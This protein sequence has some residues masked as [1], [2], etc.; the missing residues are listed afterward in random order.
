[1]NCATRGLEPYVPSEDTPWDIGRAQHLFRRIGFGGRP[2]ELEAALEAGPTATVDFLLNQATTRPFY[3]AP[4]FAYWNQETLRANGLDVFQSFMKIQR[5]WVRDAIQY[6]IREKLS[7]FWQNHLVTVYETHSCP[8]YHYQY[9]RVIEEHCFGNYSDFV[10]DMTVTPAMLFYLNGFENTK[11]NP[12]E[13][14]ARELFELFT[15]GEN[16]GYTQEDIVEASRALTGYNGWTS[17]CGGVRYA[18]WGFDDSEKTVFGV[19]GNFNYIELI[20]LLFEQR[21]EKIAEF[22]CGKLYKYYVHREANPAIVAGLAKTFRDNNFEILPVLDQLFKSAHFF[23]DANVGT[24]VKSPMELFIGYL[25]Q[26]NFGEFENHVNWG[27]WA[28]ARMGQYLGHPTDVAGWKGDRAWI[29]SNRITLRWEF[30]DGYAW[31]VHNASEETYPA[32]GKMLTN[33]SS[34]PEVISRAMIDYFIP[35][36]LV[37]EDAYATAVDVLKWDVPSNYY[38]DGTWSLDWGTASHQML[39]LLRHI[40]RMPEFQLN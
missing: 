7:L 11:E 39:L 10:K 22:I 19:T 28:A 21:S 32:F 14:Y 13:N 16:N 31:G 6:G 2:D 17:Y 30:L 5:D 23:E 1:M 3:P 35:R 25:R 26:G 27:F 8:S 36:G 38:D 24:L 34:D 37:S 4:D 33:N 40:G 15:L 12:N 18:P 9:M 29:D 20:D